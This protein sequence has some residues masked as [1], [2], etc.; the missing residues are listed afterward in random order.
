MTHTMEPGL[1]GRVETFVA[2]LSLP[3]EARSV[4]ESRLAGIGML[5]NCAGDAKPYL[6]GS[7]K[8]EA[9]RAAIARRSMR[10][11]RVRAIFRK[12]Q[13]LEEIRA[14]LPLGRTAKPELVASLV[15][16]PASGK[17]STRRV[18]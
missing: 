12:H 16:F 15:S 10:S 13:L 5:V 7:L 18:W 4:A 3:E 8:V 1:K 6:P 14:R 17:L 9:W 2:D 11:T